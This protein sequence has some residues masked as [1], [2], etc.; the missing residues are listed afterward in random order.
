MSCHLVV[1]RTLI[2]I[3]ADGHACTIARA[4]T[5][6]F[7]TDLWCSAVQV[8]NAERLYQRAGKQRRAVERVRPLLEAAEAEVGSMCT[9]Y[10][11]RPLDLRKSHRFLHVSGRCW[12]WQKPRWA[13]LVLLHDCNS[14]SLLKQPL[15][16]VALLQANHPP[17]P[18]IVAPCDKC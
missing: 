7:P 12:R 8:Q 4:R 10:V 11:C 17:P 2:S 14:H 16:D 6:V 15:L 13:R 3:C 5:S 18:S 1:G 9:L